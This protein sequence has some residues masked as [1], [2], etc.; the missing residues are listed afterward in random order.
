MNNEDLVD[1]WDEADFEIIKQWD[2]EEKNKR[3]EELEEYVKSD[4]EIRAKLLT[5]IDGLN[6]SL[7]QANKEIQELEAQLEMYENGVYFSSENDKLQ[8]R[9]DKA[10]EYIRTHR[11]PTNYCF[12]EEDLD[13]QD[14]INILEGE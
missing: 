6:Y 2:E 14:L 13:K 12:S 11:Y 4:M 1:D 3:L 7:E 5:K 9:I 8:Q 10:I